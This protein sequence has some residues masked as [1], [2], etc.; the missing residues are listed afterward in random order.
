MYITYEYIEKTKTIGLKI[1]SSDFLKKIW[2]VN[3]SQGLM[4]GVIYHMC[5][6]VCVL[7]TSGGQTVS[8]IVK[9][10]TESSFPRTKDVMIIK[11]LV[12][13]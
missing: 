6:C 12:V 8:E 13:V 11:P 10:V 2:S 1:F 7:L 4:E 9:I 5:V 3:L